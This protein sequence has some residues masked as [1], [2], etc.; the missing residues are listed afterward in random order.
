[1]NGGG[2]YY[3]LVAGFREYTPETDNRGFDAR[4][5]V[6]EIREQLSKP[7][8]RILKL[9]YCW[10]D[11]INIVNMR[12][13]RTQFSDLGNF[14]REELAAGL[15]NGAGPENEGT[16]PVWIS[17]VLDAY[18]D[19]ENTDYEG[20]DTSVRFERALIEAYYAECEKSGNRF[21]REWYAF[22]RNLRNVIAAYTAREKDLPVADSLIGSGDI[23]RLLAR[24][25]AAD[26]GLRGELDY[27]DRLL[28][29]LDD[30]A[31][32][33]EKERAIDLIR[34]EEAGELARFDYFNMNAIL[35]YLVRVNIIHR[36]IAL[37]PETGREMV[38][39]LLSSMSV[40]DRLRG[41][42]RR[43]RDNE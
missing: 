23:V 11:V 33:I 30:E 43:R 1:M 2:N 34:W 37:D 20:V 39:R 7:D 21:L 35:C 36:W 28:A 40:A 4:A 16:L 42:Q 10:Y 19:P 24:S 31:D 17:N 32:I 3:G 5:I 6:E 12:A 22:D 41:S 25:A 15:E 8:R 13:G 38:R 29:A 26:F 14:T 18:R 9:F 27:I